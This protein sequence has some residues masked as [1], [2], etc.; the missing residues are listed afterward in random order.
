MRQNILHPCVRLVCIGG[1]GA[2][3]RTWPTPFSS[4][5]LGLLGSLL[6][7]QCSLV[8]HACTP[9]P[10]T[11]LGHPPG[12]A[13]VTH[14]RGH[15]AS[16]PHPARSGCRAALPRRPSAALL[17]CSLCSRVQTAAGRAGM[18]SR[19]R[20]AGLTRSRCRAAS[21]RA[22]CRGLLGLSPEVGLD[23]QG[24][25]AAPEGE[26]AREP[27]SA[28]GLVGIASWWGSRPRCSLDTPR[29][30]Q[31]GKLSLCVGS[32]TRGLPW[33]KPVDRGWLSFFPL[34]P[35]DAPPSRYGGS[36]LALAAGSPAKPG[37]LG[38]LLERTPQF[39]LGKQR[40]PDRR[41]FLIRSWY[42]PEIARPWLTSW[43]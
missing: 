43:G 1:E 38:F 25:G 5:A 8:A 41:L 18:S 16:H 28:W 11:T 15:G 9:S 21:S 4:S 6:H 22:S 37:P 29:P 26:D 12:P 13:P 2:A 7:A 24:C 33:P 35:Q 30:P 17:C 36:R 42:F 20:P 39:L 32:V 27:P 31:C 40:G 23:A 3:S 19:R 10:A 34:H 14:T